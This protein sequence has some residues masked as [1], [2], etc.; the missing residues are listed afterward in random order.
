MGVAKRI[1]ITVFILSLLLGNGGAL[2]V[3]AEGEGGGAEIRTPVTVSINA[4]SEVMVE[5]TFTAT[6]AISQVYNLDA[7][8]YDVSFNPA[9]LSVEN[10]TAGNI[11]GTPIPVDIWTQNTTGR[12]RI[13]QNISGLVGVN[14]TGSLSVLKFHVIG[15]A[16]QSSNITLSDGV[17]S[18]NNATEIP[19]TWVEDSVKVVAPPSETTISL[20]G[21][22]NLIVLPAKPV[23]TFTSET[24]LQQINNQGGGATEIY[25]WDKAGQGW[26]SHILGV[27]FGDWDIEIGQ[28]YFIKTTKAST[29]TFD[30]TPLTVPVYTF[31]PRLTNISNAKFTVS[32]T[33]ESAVTG[34][35]EYGRS[36]DAPGAWNPVYDVRGQPVVSKTHYVTVS[37]L[38]PSWTQGYT[39][40]VISGG[41]RDNNG[42]SHYSI[43]T[44]PTLSPPATEAIYGTVNKTGGSTPADGTIVYITAQGGKALSDLVG[45]TGS[46]YWTVNLGEMRTTDLSTYLS[47]SDAT[48]ITLTA[49]GATDGR[50]T[51]TTTVGSAKAGLAT[52]LA[53]G[54]P[55]G[56][57]GG[58]NFIVLPG[59]PAVTSY[60]SETLLQ[61]INSQGGGATE[62]Y[63]WDKSGQGWNSHI[64]G[65][66]FGDWGIET[67]QA[68]FI[69]TT[70]ASTF[71]FQVMP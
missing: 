26:N 45:R 20:V 61:A 53:P 6:V 63:S 31:G 46:G 47:H 69:K 14:G 17:L 16:N 36:I 37:G 12:Y 7:C 48:L 1:L 15:T 52:T 39:F 55:I 51:Q 66:P 42:G 3:M 30:S 43:S 24:L 56:I 9:V 57:V 19:A 41:V 54:V 27:P 2:P 70:K 18:S 60:T 4:P 28:G 34:W 35:I 22:L 8:N 68:Y 33:T 32:W 38:D 59:A 40:D 50:A 44:G 13:V 49:E 5:S 65:V 29:F 21:G 10:I 71:N 11:G 67:A 64:L 62:I 23:T 58:L 25:G